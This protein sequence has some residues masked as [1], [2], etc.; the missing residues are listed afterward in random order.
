MATSSSIHGSPPTT[1][2]EYFK[3]TTEKGHTHLD[4]I[5]RDIQGVLLNFLSTPKDTETLRLTCESLATRCQSFT[6]L[7]ISE[8][9]AASK[10]VSPS[11]MSISAEA[12]RNNNSTIKALVDAEI[13][14]SVKLEIYREG[15]PDDPPRSKEERRLILESR[16]AQR[17]YTE[18]DDIRVVQLFE[19][20]LANTRDKR[21]ASK[22][23]EPRQENIL[24]GNYKAS[25]ITLTS[26]RTDLRLICP[27]FGEINLVYLSDF[28][29]FN[30]DLDTCSVSSSDSYINHP[31]T[32]RTPNLNELVPVCIEYSNSRVSSIPWET[33]D[34]KMGISADRTFLSIKNTRTDSKGLKIYPK[35]TR[36]NDFLLLP[37]GNIIVATDL[38]LQVLN[39]EGARV[40]EFPFIFDSIA[41]SKSNDKLYGLNK[42]EG[43]LVLTTLDFVGTDKVEDEILGLRPPQT[44]MEKV[45]FAWKVFK[46]VFMESLA[47]TKKS[48]SNMPRIKPYLIGTVGGVTLIGIGLLLAS[49]V[50]L[51]I[52]ATLGLFFAVL[53]TGI[54][55]GYG[56]Y[57]GAF[58][59]I[60]TL[61]F[62][63]ATVSGVAKGIFKVYRT[64]VFRN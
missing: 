61:A 6:P 37:E 32:S 60:Y 55:A 42:V 16:I 56:L 54:T 17:G 15:S 3:Y 14:S 1:R 63:I 4:L 33:P 25:R 35:G 57:L 31:S 18:V 58:I 23:I 39:H 22:N 9:T 62:L 27:A 44:T 49:F 12:I 19:R 29:K 40:Q 46:S 34:H 20:E 21:L 5:P 50:A 26:P 10:P 52:I 45:V 59:T 30:I 38:G 41:F 11:V 2:D 64:G 43:S 13:Q 36:I 7:I 8:S 24:K 53:G 48:L 28:S 51:P 47:K